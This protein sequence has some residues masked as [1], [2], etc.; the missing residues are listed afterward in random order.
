MGD[1]IVTLANYGRIKIWKEKIG[2]NLEPYG[3]SWRLRKTPG[4]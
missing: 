4:V 2:L 1:N 3:M